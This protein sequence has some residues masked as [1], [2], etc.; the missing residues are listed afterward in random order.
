MEITSPFETLFPLKSF[1]VK[2]LF[3]I[4]LTFHINKVSNMLPILL[5][6]GTHTVVMPK[7]ITKDFQ[8]NYQFP[9]SLIL[10]ANYL[11]SLTFLKIR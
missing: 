9:Q 7:S 6:K 4:Y 3:V 10:R 2:L 8:D 1:N 5:I 11:A